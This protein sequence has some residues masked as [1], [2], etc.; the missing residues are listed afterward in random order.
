GVA[1]GR[2]PAGTV[3]PAVERVATW[4]LRVLVAGT[5]LWLIPSYGD[6]TVA[7][8]LVVP[9][10]GTAV[11]LAVAFGCAPWRAAYTEAMTGL[12][13]PVRLRRL[14]DW[15]RTHPA[16]RATYD[17]LASL[18]PAWWL[19]RAWAAV[20]LVGTLTYGDVTGPFA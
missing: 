8:P 15:L 14:R 7:A 3:T 12:P 5:V 2:P 13:D 6:A 9:W 17:Y 18:R 11:I 4:W 20:V 1:A 19:A 10:V 16:G